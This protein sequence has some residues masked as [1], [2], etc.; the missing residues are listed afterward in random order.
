MITAYTME[1]TPLITS[2]EEQLMLQQAAD[3]SVR[4]WCA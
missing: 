3:L 2:Q 1:E 4:G